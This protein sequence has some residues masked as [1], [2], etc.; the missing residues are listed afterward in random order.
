MWLLRLTKKK[1]EKL[2]NSINSSLFYKGKNINSFKSP[3]IHKS[4]FPLLIP[5]KISLTNLKSHQS[6]EIILKSCFFYVSGFLNKLMIF[7][8]TY[9][10]NERSYVPILQLPKTTGFFLKKIYTILIVKSNN[11]WDGIS[12]IKKF[13]FS[14]VHV[15]C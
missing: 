1:K 15:N 4:I 8:S 13:W 5:L 14:Q 11:I 7:P 12:C 9:P 2:I 10:P 3:P 6:N